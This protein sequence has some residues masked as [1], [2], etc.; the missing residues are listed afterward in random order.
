MSAIASMPIEAE[1]KNAQMSARLFF[2][3]LSGGRVLSANPDGSDLKTVINE[4]RKLPDGL[5]LDVV[6]GHIYWTN[7]GDPNR[8]DGSIMRSDL[9][10]KNM[11]TIVPS[12]G[13]FTPKQLQIVGT[14]L[15]GMSTNP[16]RSFGPAVQ[17]DS[18]HALWIY[19]IAPSTG[20]LAA[21]ETFLR[22]RQG[23]APQCAKLHHANDKR[24][25]FH[26][27]TQLPK[28]APHANSTHVRRGNCSLHG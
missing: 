7:M 3:D 1:A 21:A 2:L 20:M 12:G 22:I 27:A 4:G 10:G 14:A 24:C 8:N 11:I 26:H 18:W 6:A 23:V 19:F 17:A 28:R 16:A 9:S 5:V 15:S 25:I 13:T